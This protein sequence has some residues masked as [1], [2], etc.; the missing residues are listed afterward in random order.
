ML[1]ELLTVEDDDWTSVIDDLDRFG[2]AESSCPLIPLSKL[3]CHGSN[4]LASTLTV[5]TDNE[6]EKTT[7]E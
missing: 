4:A 2:L 5:T 7:H 3:H 1:G 6:E